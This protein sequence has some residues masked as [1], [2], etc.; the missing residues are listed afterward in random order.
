MHKQAKKIYQAPSIKVVEVKVEHA[1][2]SFVAGSADP[3]VDPQDGTERYGDG[4]AN[5]ALWF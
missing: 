4:S 2:Q 1:F 3:V 5:A